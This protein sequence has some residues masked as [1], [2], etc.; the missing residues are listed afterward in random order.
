MRNF[1][2]SGKGSPAG[3]GK[4]P[5]S[6]SSTKG[7]GRSSRP[8]GRTDSKKTS[9]K[10]KAPGKRFSSDKKGDDKKPFFREKS[11]GKKFSAGKGDDKKPF[12][13]SKPAG[14]RFSDEKERGPKTFKKKKGDDEHSG[15]KEFKAGSNKFKSSERHDGQDFVPEKSGKRNFEDFKRTKTSSPRGPKKTDKYSKPYK[16]FV[17]K[18]KSDDGLIRLN[19]YIS[20]AGIC[21]RREADEYIKTGVVK[22]NGEI[23]TELGH[24]IKPTDKV[25]F[26]ERTIKNES[27]VYILLNKPKDYITTSK[28][29]QN[30]RTVMELVSGVKE[31]IF[32]VGRLD[33]HTTGLLMLTNDGEMADTLMHPRK[34]IVKIYHV[35]L[36]KKLPLPKLQQLADGLELEDGFFQPDEVSYAEGM[37]KNHIGIEIHSGKNRIVRRLFEHLG[38]KVVKLDRVFYAGLSKKGLQRGEWR[39]LKD[40]EV[41]MLKMLG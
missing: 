5:D 13:R 9:P 23:I 19:K 4:K 38:Y 25:Q 40:E 31:R 20:N 11:A 28:D 36:E 14:S 8:A 33:R 22:V 1:S 41:R 2:R 24:K 26:G 30:R 6:G 17:K 39:H 3:S 18:E 15:K 32:P 34:K 16:P 37:E 10:D 7:K 29:P 35:E 21:S 27:P 12:S